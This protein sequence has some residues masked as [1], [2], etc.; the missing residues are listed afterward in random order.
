M[1]KTYTTELC[2]FMLATSFECN[3]GELQRAVDYYLDNIETDSKFDL[4]IC[5]DNLPKRMRKFDRWINNTKRHENVNDVIVNNLEIPK[6]ENIY[7]KN[8]IPPFDLS[9]LNMGRSH[10]INHLFYETLEYLF[11]TK[12]KNFLLLECDTKPVTSKWYDVC[13]NH[14][15]THDFSI[16]GS[17]YKGVKRDFILSLYFGPHLNGVAIYRN[18]TRTQQMLRDSKS[19]LIKSLA[20]DHKLPE[21]RRVYREFMNYDVAIYLHLKRMR[22]YTGYHDTN[23]ITNISSPGNENT[24]LQSVLHEFPDTQILH[25]KNLYE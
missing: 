14:C 18:C 19:F 24:S 6:D 7:I 15:K 9:K 23:F 5:L 25:Q 1:I 2:V 11:T 22:S 20:D 21:S 4:L 10:G 8:L 16:A 12:Y 13:V 17:K 3:E